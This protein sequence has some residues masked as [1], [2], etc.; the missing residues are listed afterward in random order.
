MPYRNQATD[1]EREQFIQAFERLPNQ[2][3]YVK[4]I[5]RLVVT[6]AKEHKG[7]G[8]IDFIENLSKDNKHGFPRDKYT[9]KI[10][11][12]IYASLPP[13]ERASILVEIAETPRTPK[14]SILEQQV[15]VA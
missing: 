5:A 13:E 2:N 4:E 15:A 14:E 7:S 8:N 3:G 6:S 10:V 9:L 12:Q 1:S 11:G